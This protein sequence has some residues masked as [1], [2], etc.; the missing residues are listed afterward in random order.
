MTALHSAPCGPLLHDTLNARN[1][2]VSCLTID[3]TQ[4][5]S[6]ICFACTFRVRKEVDFVDEIA[7]RSNS[8]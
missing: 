1:L 6:I 8:P 7:D 5:R 4:L 3:Q 2:W